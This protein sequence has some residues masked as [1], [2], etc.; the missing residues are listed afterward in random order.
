MN[1]KQRPAGEI[2]IVTPSGHLV[3]CATRKEKRHL[4]VRQP[5]ASVAFCRGPR[6]QHAVLGL[7]QRFGLWTG[8]RSRGYRQANF[9]SMRLPDTLSRVILE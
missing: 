3:T 5:A 8:N 1:S 6:R 4:L 9:D 7:Q 2:S